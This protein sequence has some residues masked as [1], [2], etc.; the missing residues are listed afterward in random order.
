MKRKSERR[1][2][3]ATAPPCSRRSSSSSPGVKKSRSSTPQELHRLE[4][5]DD[6][7]LDITDRLCFA[8][9]YSRPKSASNEHYFSIDNELEYENFYAD[10]G[11][12]N[13]AMVYRYCCKIN[14][15]LKSITMLRKKIIHFTGT[16]QRKQANAAFLIGCYMV[17]YLGRAPEDAYRTLIFGDTAYIPFRDAAYGSCSF[18]ITLLDCF[19]A[20][21]KAIQYGF[22]NFNSFNLDEYEHYEKAENGDFNWIIPERF[23]A[24]CGPHS[25]SRLESG[26]H[27]HSP[28]TYIPYFKNHNV[29]TIIRLNKRM[30][31][32]KRFTDAGFDH[33]DLF[34]PD[35]STPAEAIVQEFLDICENVEGAIAVHCKAGLGRTGTLIGCYLMKH[36]R[37]TAA[38]S[39][40]WL[41]ICR[42]GS[43]IGPQQQ[44][45]VM[46]QSSLWLEGDYFRQKLRGQENGALREAFSK[47]LSDVDDISINGLENQDSQEPEPYSDDDEVSGVTQGDRLRALKSRRQPKTN[48]IPLTVILQSSV[49]SSKTPEPNLSGSAGITKRTTRSASGKSSLKSLAPWR[50][51]R[52][53]SA[54]QHMPMLALCPAISRTKTVLR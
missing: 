1:S 17:I 5:Q 51:R 26:Y 21:K 43:V 49:Q 27:Q 2:A 53:R 39:I 15:K 42:P 7:Y 48:A 20:V 50:E 25:R 37:M 45:L 13:L 54:L 16:D 34:F 19:H 46:K 36:Y 14:K 41:R 3:W 6:L 31:D 22:L 44:F 4:Q 40:A 32:A 30:Y 35:G 29:T 11:P 8:I 23:L 38:E 52:R 24:F 47:H 10:F 12:L 28:E 18:Y 9:L 33:H